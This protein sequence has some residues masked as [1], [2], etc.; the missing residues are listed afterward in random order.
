MELG[1][2]WDKRIE[3]FIFAIII[4]IKL[5]AVLLKKRLWQRC[6]LVNFA[7]FLRTLFFIEH[8]RSLLLNYW[9]YVFN[10]SY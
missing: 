7:K 1:L 6:F 2:K 5:L 3:Y 8:L 9:G 10:H 4:L